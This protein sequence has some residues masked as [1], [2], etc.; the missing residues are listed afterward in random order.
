MTVVLIAVYVPIGFQG[1]LTGAL[2]T[3]FAFTLVGAVTISADR[4][5]DAVADDVLALLLPHSRDRSGLG[6]A[7][8]R[9]HRPR[10]SIGCTARYERRLRGSLHYLPVTLVFAA[11]VLGSIYF[12]YTSANS[13]LAPQEDQG[14][15][16]AQSRPRRR[17]RRCSRCRC[18]RAVYDIVGRIP[19][20]D[21]CSSSTCP[22]SI[23]AGMVLKPWDQ[24]KRT[25]DPAAAA[26][27][28]GDWTASPA[29]RSSAFQPPPLPGATGLPM[30]FVI[31][32]TEPF[33]AAQHGR[34]AV[35]ARGAT[36]AACSSSW[37]P[38]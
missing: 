33:D 6:G 7:A 19:E 29:R 3:E 14:V 37:T 24:R 23:I 18:T 38:I 20:T 36:A 34:P 15:V 12:L 25:H 30:Q 11:L 22:A 10:A 35:P 13:E 1:G 26:D 17:T 4:R 27:A 28:A 21:Q 2:F 16:I 8:D 5:A 31:K 9:I 32:T